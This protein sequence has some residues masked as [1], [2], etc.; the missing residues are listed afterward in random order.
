MTVAG[1]ELLARRVEDGW[2]VRDGGEL[3]GSFGD[4]KAAAAV[5]CVTRD[6]AWEFRRLRGGNTE[7]TMGTAV[8]ARYESKLLSGGTIVLPD[9]S[10]FRLR[11][12]VTGEIWRLRR[13]RREVV[14]DV[15]PMRI[16]WAIRLEPVASELQQIPL[17]TM[18]TF[19]A[20]LS[21]LDQPGGG[22]PESPYVGF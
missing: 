11:R 12:P 17:I 20:V 16:G 14:L 5:R 18:F 8:A 3:F 13:G 1:R 6:G 22:G 4:P 10:H 19:H 7:A 2:E 15:A 21:E 9:D